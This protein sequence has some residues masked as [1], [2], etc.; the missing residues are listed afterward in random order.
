MMYV[1]ENL[2][3]YV[4]QHK[5]IQY[6]TP[7]YPCMGI[8]FM[9]F[10]LCRLSGR[11]QPTTVVV[12][13]T[14]SVPPVRRSRRSVSRKTLSD[15]T[16]ANRFSSMTFQHIIAFLIFRLFNGTTG[17]ECQSGEL[18]FLKAP[19]LRSTSIITSL[20]YWY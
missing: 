16:P 9:I 15:L 2:N 11:S 12:T 19:C 6:I 7:M 14:D 13:N 1:K 18:L 5:R 3:H 4:D 20:S 10:Q 17:P 8:P